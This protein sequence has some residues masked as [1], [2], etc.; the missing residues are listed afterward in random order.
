MTKISSCCRYSALPFPQFDMVTFR[1]VEIA[2]ARGAS[3]SKIVRVQCCSRMRL[4]EEVDDYG[5]LM[6][7]GADESNLRVASRLIKPTWID[8]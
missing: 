2:R 4:E 7:H 6:I 1:G 3:E 5:I 8:R